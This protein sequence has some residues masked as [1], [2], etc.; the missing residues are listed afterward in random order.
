MCADPE[1]CRYDPAVD[2]LRTG[3]RFLSRG[4]RGGNA[5][6]T[7]LGALLAARGILKMLYRPSREL[8]YSRRLAPGD[9]IQIGLAD[10]G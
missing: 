7:L 8:V 5:A 6:V 3:A 10:E 1:L 4:L 9:R 2:P